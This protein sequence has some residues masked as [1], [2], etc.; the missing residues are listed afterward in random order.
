[1]V[2]QTVGNP[3]ATVLGPRLA[4]GIEAM[5]REARITLDYSLQSL[6]LVDR[7]IDGLRAGGPSVEA[8]TRT[9]QGFGAYVGEVLVRE[10]GAVWTDFNTAQRDMFGQPF[11]IRT[12]DGRLWN[13]LGKA[14]KRYENGPEDSLRLFCLSVVGQAGV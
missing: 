12:P 14:V 9:L 11:G 10:I 4:A 5:A 8:A 2:E 6:A 13:P 3:P 7:I 1:M